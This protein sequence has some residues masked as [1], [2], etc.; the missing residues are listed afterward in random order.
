MVSSAFG[1]LELNS[2]A[3]LKRLPV[4]V[5]GRD[6]EVVERAELSISMIVFSLNKMRFHSKIGAMFH[7]SGEGAAWCGG[8]RA[9]T[10]SFQGV[11]ALCRQSMSGRAER[12]RDQSGNRRRC[13]RQALPVLRTSGVTSGGAGQFVKQLACRAYAHFFIAG[14]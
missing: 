6:K 8:V 2:V 1:T 14:E 7:R 10:F 4:A 5:V 9:E 12:R 13:C 3:E 11:A